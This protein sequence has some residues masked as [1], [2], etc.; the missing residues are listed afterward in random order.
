[1]RSRGNRINLMGLFNL[2]GGSRTKAD[3]DREIARLQG[4]VEYLKARMADAKAR[5]KMFSGVRTSP[6]QYPPMIAQKKAQIANL[7]AE[8]KSAPK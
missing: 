6:E 3:I 4:E 2:F 8:R 1:M 5:Q 7:K